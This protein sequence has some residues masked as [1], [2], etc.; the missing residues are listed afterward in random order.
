[1]LGGRGRDSRSRLQE[2]HEVP[3]EQGKREEKDSKPKGLAGTLQD[4]LGTL[5]SLSKIN[6]TKLRICL[7]LHFRRRN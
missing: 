1:M 4:R 5:D 7:A 6:M 2:L 3:S